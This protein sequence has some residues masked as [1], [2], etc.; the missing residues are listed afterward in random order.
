MAL[1]LKKLCE[2]VKEIFKKPTILWQEDIVHDKDKEIFKKEGLDESPFDTLKLK[3]KLY[4]SFVQGK[5]K[6]HVKQCGLARVC[7]LTETPNEPYPW[8]TWLRIFQWLGQSKENKIWQIYIYSS[9]VKRILPADGPLGP[10]HV[11]GGYTYP[12]SSDCVV[13]YRYEEVTRVLIHELLHAAC[14]DDMNKPVEFREAATE[15]WAELFLVAILSKGNY[16]KGKKLWLIQDHYIQD[17]NYTVKTFHNV[18]TMNDYAARYT[19]LREGVFHLYNIELD[20]TY[21]PKR[22]HISRFTSPELDTYII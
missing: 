2:N 21:V 4:D 13:I 7:I 8:A 3:R 17:L 6:I 20:A 12:C 14:T 22:I 15:A 5:A 10:E 19:T 18:H 16:N 9:P 11:N 1:V